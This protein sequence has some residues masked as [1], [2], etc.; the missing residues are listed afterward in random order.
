L[1]K[2]LQVVI[3]AIKHQRSCG[4][5]R[6]G[7]GKKQVIM[8]SDGASERKKEGQFEKRGLEEKPNRGPGNVGRS[9]K[10]VWT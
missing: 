4:D 7:R 5:V 10:G 6:K 3:A 1:W 9:G 8:K 2:V